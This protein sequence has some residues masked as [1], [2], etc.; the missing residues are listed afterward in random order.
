MGLL[1]GLTDPVVMAAVEKRYQIVTRLAE[2]MG[3][4]RDEARQALFCFE[5]ITSSEGHT[6]H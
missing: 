2:Q 3:V 1:D 5:S 6:L 4:T